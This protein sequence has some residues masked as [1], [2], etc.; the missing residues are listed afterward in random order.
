MGEFHVRKLPCLS[1]VSVLLASCNAGSD[2]SESL[3]SS[4]A[5]NTSPV[6]VWSGTD[7]VSG[8]A[9]TALINSSGQ[10]AFLRADG[11]QFVVRD[12]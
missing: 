5:S 11:T 10:T 2:S 1:L 12:F 4:T 9:V 6:G 8:F 3:D 7:S